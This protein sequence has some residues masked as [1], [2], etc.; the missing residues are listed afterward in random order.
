MASNFDCQF[1]VFNSFLLKDNSIHNEVDPDVSF[2]QDIPSLDTKYSLPLK[3][4]TSDLVSYASLK[5]GLMIVL[6]K[7]SFIS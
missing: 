1:S 5:H 6:V 7:I 2:F 4:W 3:S